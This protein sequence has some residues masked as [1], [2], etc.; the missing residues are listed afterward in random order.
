M[1]ES[2]QQPSSYADIQ[3]Q[4][5]TPQPA[6]SLVGATLK[7]TQPGEAMPEGWLQATTAL[8]DWMGIQLELVPQRP[9]Q[10]L[11]GAVE[12][13]RGEKSAPTAP[14]FAPWQNWSPVALQN[15]C[16][17]HLPRAQWFASYL[18]DHSIGNPSRQ[19]RLDV[20]LMTPHP[21]TCQHDAECDARMPRLKLLK[22]MI[23]AARSEGRKKLA[24]IVH[25]L[26]RNA[27]VRQ[28][29]LADRALTRDGIEID[30]VSVEDA[31]G[32]LMRNAGRWDAIIAMP[33][34][35]SIVFAVLAH[36]ASS[37]GPWPL[38]WHGRDSFVIGA[39]DLANGTARLPLSATLLVKSLALAAFHSGLGHGA[40]RL[41]ESAAQLWLR[42]V[43]TAGKHSIVPYANEVSDAEFIRLICAGAGISGRTA[44]EWLAIGAPEKPTVTSK[45]T[46]LHVVSPT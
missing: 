33:E 3:G 36:S 14:L 16:S 32:P 9:A 13:A 28:M 34:L 19:S 21:A 46:R 15:D 8:L 2:T 44:P 24:I 45:P 20:V 7:I 17:H 23:G 31:L 26:A 29:L 6:L 30:I 43:T 5:A 27:I 37:Q 40:R 25:A 10:G 41:H 38:V 22:A 1:P 18:S 4:A 39:E 35:R 42:G 12:W 11:K